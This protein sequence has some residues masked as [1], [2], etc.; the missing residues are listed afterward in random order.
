MP[1]NNQ[2]ESLIKIFYYV[3]DQIEFDIPVFL[4]SA[5]ETLRRKRGQVI[6]KNNLLIA[7]CRAVGI[8]ARAKIINQNMDIAKYLI[9]SFNYYGMKLLAPNGIVPHV[10]PEVSYQ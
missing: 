8:K 3:R 10:I 2:K 6:T 1:K 9:G 7:L 5:S 4:C